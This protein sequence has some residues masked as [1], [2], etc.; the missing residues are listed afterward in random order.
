MKVQQLENIPSVIVVMLSD[1]LTGSEYELTVGKTVA[2]TPGPMDVDRFTLTFA[3]KDVLASQPLKLVKE[4]GRLKIIYPFNGLTPV[5][6]YTLDGKI[7]YQDEV[8]FENEQAI[9][10]YQIHSNRPYIM[11]VA[12][13]NLKFLIK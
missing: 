13:Q 8:L 5:S 1:N 9:I 6:I 4:N 2:F 10:P 3:Y 11:Q 7:S 12:D